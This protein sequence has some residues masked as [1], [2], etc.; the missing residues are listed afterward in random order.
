MKKSFLLLVILVLNG[1][2]IFSRSPPRGEF[3]V[4]NNS[5]QSI[6]ITREFAIPKVSSDSGRFPVWRQDMFDIIFFNISASLRDM[7]K[8]SP[9]ITSLEGIAIVEIQNLINRLR[10]Q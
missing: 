5:S 2:T 6:I 7:E 8:L 1:S 3:V 10:V 4:E 9:V